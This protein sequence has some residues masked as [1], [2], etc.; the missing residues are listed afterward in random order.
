VASPPVPDKPPEPSR[1]SIRENAAAGAFTDGAALEVRAFVS[2]VAKGDPIRVA[3]R[4]RPEKAGKAGE[5]FAGETLKWSEVLPTLRV[6]V[7]GPDGKSQ[8]LTVG[9][10]PA[11]GYAQSLE[12]LVQ[13]LAIDGQQIAAGAPW[14][15]PVADLFG[16]VGSYVV[17]VA[18]EL[19]TNKR[20]LSL[21]SGPLTVEVADGLRPMAE[22]EAEAAKSAQAAR[23]MTDVPRPTATAVEDVEGNVWFRFQERELTARNDV[24]VT[25]VLV[26][27]AG[28]ELHV[29]SFR[30]FSCVA[31]G[32][33]VATPGGAVRIESLVPG[34]EVLSYDVARRERAVAIVVHSDASYAES[35]LEL[36][37]L[38]VTPSHPVFSLAGAWRLAGELSAGDRL[39]SLDLEPI[40]VSPR[41]LATPATVYDLSVT[42]P[43][44][45]FAGGVL[46]HNK[47]AFVPIGRGEPWEGKFYRRAAKRAAP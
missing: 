35:L 29:D 46:V 13:E 22:L 33:L 20:T 18:G 25:E 9:K 47:A 38:R 43:H 17:T 21:A 8:E 16:K 6:T 10:A 36:G 31:E 24:I 44:T 28:K 32:T 12:S 27:R 34:D 14:K 41:A 15:A 3:I 11:Q 4:V 45:Y 37:A 23:K 19:K 30:H 40:D 7:K 39:L 5:A 1:A 2:K 42:A 26:D